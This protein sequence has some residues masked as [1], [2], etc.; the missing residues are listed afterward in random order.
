VIQDDKVVG[1]A[2]QG[3]PGL[4]NTGFFIPPPIIEHFLKDISNGKYEGFPQ[5]GI[6]V[7]PLQN[8]AFRKFLKLPEND[9]GA[10]IDSLA[11]ILTTEKVLKPDDVV[12][13]VGEYPVASDGS[14]LY[15]GNRLSSAL[16]FQSVQ[17]GESLPLQIWRDGKKMDVSLPLY[18]Y[19]A[20]RSSGFQYTALPRY[21]VR[22]GLVFTPLSLDYLRSQGRNAPDPANAEL[23]YE[24][25]YRRNESPSTVRSEPIV[26]ASVLADAVNANF[27]TRGRALVDKVNGAKIDKLDDVINA[28]ESNTNAFDIIEFIPHH[29]LESLDRAEVAKV[30]ANILKTYSIAEDRRL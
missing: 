11:A 8:P 6:R 17:S 9:V 10:R 21:Y 25:Y 24:L 29:N 1:V 7:V 15:E 16:A 12:L 20:D 4:E 30:N 19:T 18:V 3:Q 5:A 28:F 26:L 2:F 27:V 23:Y 13:Q 14:I 22:G